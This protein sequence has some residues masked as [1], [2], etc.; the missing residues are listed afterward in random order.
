MSE[1][2]GATLRVLLNSLAFFLLL[3][4]GGYMVK[5]S[6]IWGLV[7]FLSAFDQLEDVYF[8]VTK[9]RLIPTWL[10]PV[11]IVLEGI[12]AIV[13]VSMFFFG[14]IYWYTFDNWFFFVWMVVSALIAWSSIEDIVEGLRIISARLS[15]E[16]VVASLANIAKF[17]FFRRV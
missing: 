3:I 15:G 13:G 7:I 2:F 16:P 1:G 14:L 12:L 5:Y 6:P 10:R 17:R 9:S 4:L 11:D 8:Y